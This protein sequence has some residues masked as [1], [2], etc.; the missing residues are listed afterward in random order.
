M[1]CALTRP[2]IAIGGDTFP[3]STLSDH[4]LRFQQIDEVGDQGRK[5]CP[6]TARLQCFGG[7]C[8]CT[9]AGLPTASARHHC[10]CTCALRGGQRL[11]MAWPV[12]RESYT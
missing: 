6:R 10:M 11:H 4:C 7:A 3:G 8:A 12:L 2:G 9:H 1:H 5:G